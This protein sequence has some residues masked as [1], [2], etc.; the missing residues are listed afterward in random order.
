MTACRGC[1]ENLL[2]LE[3]DA[4]SN[5]GLVLQRCLT[6]QKKNSE[7]GNDAR[8]S[9]L[10]G[11]MLAADRGKACYEK[12]FAMREVYFSRI[13]SA[14]S[15]RRSVKTMRFET[16]GRLI[17]GLGGESPLETGLTLLSPYGVPVIPGSALKGL[18]A[19]Y[20]DQVWGPEEK[21]Y[22]AGR[23]KKGKEI[24]AVGDFYKAMFGTT[25]DSGHITFHDAWIRPESLKSANHLG[26][27][28]DVM[29][30]HHGHYYSSEGAEGFPTDF[31]EPNPVTFL[32][33][34]GKFEIVLECDDPSE[35]GQAWLKIVGELLGK[36]LKEWG[37]GGKTSSGYGRMRSIEIPKPN[38]AEENQGPKAGEMLTVFREKNNKKGNPQIYCKVEGKRIRCG[39]EVKGADIPIPENGEGKAKLLEVVKN[40]NEMEYVITFQ[41]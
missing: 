32:S 35:N 10:K 7:G 24:E 28:E 41:L 39:L 40:G 23:F 8:S 6:E 17:I 3:K 2:K 5:P 13:G 37:I 4:A 15:P 20:C 9:L 22:R 21:Q 29:T 16:E 19:H 26:L 18:A 25:E 14:Q 31:D 34:R 33:V 36:A 38:L 11:A 12:A 30:P 27:V 1:L